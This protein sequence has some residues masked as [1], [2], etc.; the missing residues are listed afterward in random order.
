MTFCGPGD[1]FGELAVIDENPR[2]ASAI[3]VKDTVL[4]ILTRDRFREHLRRSPQL[5]LNFMRALSVRVRY[6]TQQMTSLTQLDVPARL[7]RKLL[8]LAQ[9]YGIVESD[10][11][12]I[13]LTLTQSDLASLTG[14]TRESV[15]KALGHFKRQGVIL[16]QQGTITVLDPE[17]LRDLAS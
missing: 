16:T 1:V 3:A 12:R 10:G 7:A 17:A 9:Q 5:G 2:S 11:V 13:R 14:A 15:N 8:E 4:H 6:N